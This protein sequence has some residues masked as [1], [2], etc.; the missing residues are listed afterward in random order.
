MTA[1]LLAA[2]ALMVG[3]DP[4]LRHAGER[5]RPPDHRARARDRP[6]VPRRGRR[7]RRPTRASTR[8]TSTGTCLQVV[9]GD[10]DAGNGRSKEVERQFLV[11]GKVRATITIDGAKAKIRGTAELVGKKKPVHEVHDD[12][13]YL[14]TVDGTH[15]RLATDLVLSYDGVARAADVRP[16]VPLRPDGHEGADRLRSATARR[17][18]AMTAGM[19]T[20]SYAAPHT[21]R[22][23]T[24]ATA[25]RIRATRSRWP[26]A[27]WGSPPPHRWTCA[28]TGRA[29]QADGLREVGQRRPR[30][31]RRRSAAARPPRGAGPAR[32]AGARG[33]RP[34]PPRRTQPHLAKEKVDA[35]IERPSTG[36]TRN[37]NVPRR[38]RP[39][40]HVRGLEG[41]A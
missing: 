19:P 2:T 13:G 23:A 34:L 4:G 27:Y 25:A 41:Q 39:S 15:R 24:S 31:A 5:L 33:P 11:D 22:P 26:T 10:P 35:L 36:G 6:G 3:S 30:R 21:A 17:A 40:R 12:A 9:L 14:I 16:G 38:S 28:S 37:P 32:C 20:P 7:P 8:T 1:A 18:E 29:R